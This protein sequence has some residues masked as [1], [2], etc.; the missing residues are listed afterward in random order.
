MAAAYVAIASELALL[1]PF[2]VGIRRHLAPIALAATGLEAGRQRHPD[3]SLLFAL[4][5][6]RY[7][8]LTLPAGLLLYGAGPH[9]AP[10]L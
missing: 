6:H 3:G 1:I 4:L 5:P 7:L 9:R 8:L 2:Y 10:C